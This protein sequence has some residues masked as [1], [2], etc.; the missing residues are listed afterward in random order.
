MA[1]SVHRLGMN[2]V[3]R[4]LLKVGSYYVALDGLKVPEIYVLLPPEN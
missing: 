1:N 3:F 2:T 4:F